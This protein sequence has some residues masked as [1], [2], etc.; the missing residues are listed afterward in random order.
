ME[1]K[2]YQFKVV[3]SVDGTKYTAKADDK[4]VKL[5]NSADSANKLKISIIPAVKGIKLISV[6]LSYKHDFGA[7]EKFF[8][9]GYQSWT[10]SREYDKDDKQKGLNFPCNAIP[11]ARTFA[12]SSG[13]YDFTR[14][15]GKGY[16][17]SFTYTYLRNDD[18]FTLIGSMSEKMAYTIIYAD[19]KKGVLLLE[20]DVEGLTIDDEY[21]LYDIESFDGGY[22]EVFDKYFAAMNIKKPRVPHL[23]GYTSWYNY[24]Q[25][26]NEEI[27]LRDLEGITAE[28][29]K[30]I[31]IFQ[32][33]DGSETMVG[34]WHNID[35][36]KFPNGLKPIVEKIHEKKLLA[37]LWLAPFS[38]QFKAKVVEEHPEWLVKKPNGKNLIGGFA[39]NGFYVLDFYLPEVR[40]YIKGFFNEVFD[41]WGFDM[42]KLDFLYSICIQ[43][44]NNKTRGTIM[45]E[46]MEFL[47]ECC[48]DKLILGCGVPLGPSFGIVDA[49]RI[50][51]DVELSF[52]DKYY[53]KITNQEVISARLAMNNSIFRRH[54]SGRAFIN[55]PDVF[56]L[57]D[58]GA[59]LA[60]FSWEQKL[61]L[62]KIN[63]MFGNVLFVSDNV[64]AYDEKKLAVLRESLK[65]FN[66]KVLRAGYIDKNTI[67]IV[68]VENKITYTLVYDILTGVNSVTEAK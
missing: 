26:I 46:A 27:I 36:V 1:L 14:Y 59:H 42:V 48:H 45:C 24:F 60:K 16:F 5:K 28:G 32:I 47:R 30:D 66:G 17:H 21:L 56:F 58:D 31:N 67:E 64:G 55:D 15:G 12:S 50:S 37:G 3:Y 54:L 43:P 68:W 7:N 33:D 10:T 25:K 23:A 51:C 61:L 62:A 18:K 52:K 29:N 2:N 49:C 41:D 8:V 44:R 63:H 35:P 57:R 4:F 53:V 40:E 19:M 39:W 11:L 65:K 20:K 34:D 13:D 9:N 38:A 6:A 22:D